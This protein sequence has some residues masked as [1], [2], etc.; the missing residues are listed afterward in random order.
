MHNI[1]IGVTKKIIKLWISGKDKS[2]RI[3]KRLLLVLNKRLLSIRPI[4]E[5]NRKPRIINDFGQFK[6]N[7]FRSLLLYYLPVCLSGILGAKYITHFRLLSR[8]VYCLL[9]TEISDEELIEVENDLE[10][11]VNDFQTLYGKKNM[12]MNIHL[13]KHIPNNIRNFGP[14]WTHSAFPFESFNS[15]LLSFVT[16][17]TDVL[18][19]ISTKYIIYNLCKESIISKDEPIELLGDF[20]VHRE[21][22]SDLKIFGTNQIVCLKNLELKIFKRMQNQKSIFTS[23]MYSRAKKT[24]DYFIG[25]N[26]KA[27]FGIVEYYFYNHGTAFA[28]LN[29]FETVKSIDHILQVKP[30]KVDCW[31]EPISLILNSYTT[32]SNQIFLI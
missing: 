22:N 2:L 27:T 23:K 10:Q 32:K 29:L 17:K 12:T 20:C 3:N 11:F 25:C 6:A 1:L 14:L 24:I 7:E 16:G 26:D 28:M 9:K 15:V 13:L 31:L 8:S 18:H 30:T 4:S 21:D 19:Q 5:I